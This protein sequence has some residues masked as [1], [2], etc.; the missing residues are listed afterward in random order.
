M[1]PA[2]SQDPLPVVPGRPDIVQG[3]DNM[4]Q[5]TGPQDDWRPPGGDPQ[6]NWRQPSGPQDNWRQPTGPQDNWRQPTGPQDNWRQPT[7]PQDNWPTQELG[8]GGGESRRPGGRRP[9]RWGA[10]IALVALLAGGGALAATELTS[11]PGPATAGS[12]QAAALNSVLSSASSPASGAA[13][14]P[15]PGTAAASGT[16]AVSGTTAAS[17]TTAAASSADSGALS[18]AV[19][20]GGSTVAGRCGRAVIRLRA[21]R[22]PRAA[23]IVGRFCRNRLVRLRAL[24]GMHGQF[25]FRTKSGSRT[26]AFARGVLESATAGQVVVKSA[27]GSTWTWYLVASTV[28]REQGKAVGRGVLGSGEQVF[29][30]GPVVGGKND[31]RLIV[32][33]PGNGSPA[34]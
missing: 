11:G 14:S 31:A 26:I 13:S 16:T 25:T 30:G 23:V 20:A 3:M 12:G 2:C 7:G 10:G 18:S 6:D 8:A 22:H 32:I 24:G 1:F 9:M 19:S 29:A 21:A 34:G 17:A 28:V 4:Y 33:R 15:A 5:P 27:D